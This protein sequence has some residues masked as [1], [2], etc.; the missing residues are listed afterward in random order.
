MQRSNAYRALLNEALSDELLASIR[1]HLQQQRA[2]G[3]NT[4]RA[5]V[6][7]KTNRFAGVRPAHRPRKP[8]IAD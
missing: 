4:F 8:N 3:H 1:L 7:A 2:L 6:E 5:M